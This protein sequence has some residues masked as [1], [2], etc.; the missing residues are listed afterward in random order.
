MDER[1]RDD[2]D[3]QRLVGE[4]RGD[5]NHLLRTV[6]KND[7]HAIKSREGITK[8]LTEI[9]KKIDPI[10]VRLT[11]AEL[12]IKTHEAVIKKLGEDDIGRAA[13]N[14]AGRRAVHAVWI[15]ASILLIFFGEW[16]RWPIEKFLKLL[17]I[18]GGTP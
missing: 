12:T 10:E 9:N 8:Q 6:E 7:E 14:L 13:V 2:G 5:I 17:R 11:T 15:F 4:L 1:E 16:I 18:G 3:T